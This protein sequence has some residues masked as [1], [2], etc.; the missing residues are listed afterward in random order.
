MLSLRQDHSRG[1]GES[2][3]MMDA[4]SSE[5]NLYQQM[6]WRCTVPVNGKPCRLVGEQDL[7]VR[8]G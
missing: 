7:D 2:G 6:L 8:I 4:L 3:G 5:T 1:W